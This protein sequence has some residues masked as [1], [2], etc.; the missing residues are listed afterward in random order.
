MHAAGDKRRL[1]TDRQARIESGTI[2][3][4]DF[5]SWV[6]VGSFDEASD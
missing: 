5:G 3:L 4:L 6:L 2:R 1:E